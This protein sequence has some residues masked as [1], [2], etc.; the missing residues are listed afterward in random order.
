MKIKILFKMRKKN[1]NI[2]LLGFIMLS[3][4]FNACYT[5][6]G[7]SIDPNTTSFFVK[8]LENRAS[9]AQ[10]ALAQEVTERMKSKI[11]NE[12]RLKIVQENP[13][14]EFS[15]YISDYRVSAEAPNSTQGSALNRLTIVIHIDYKDIKVEKNNYN[16]DFTFSLPFSPNE[17]LAA[18]QESLNRKITDQIINEII[19]ATFNNW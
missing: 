1:H 9:L 13:D 17:S 12:T 4:L 6:K 11:R 5:F 7:F 18:V 8:N 3:L 16:K 2:F 19:L 15:G 14:I 10:P